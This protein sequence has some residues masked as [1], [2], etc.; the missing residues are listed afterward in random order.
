MALKNIRKINSQ[1]F[2][3]E[4]SNYCQVLKNDH[5][6]KVICRGCS[7]KLKVFHDFYN[8][9]NEARKGFL[10]VIMKNIDL[11]CKEVNFDSVDC[12]DDIP[13]VKL[14][15]VADIFVTEIET[16][17]LEG[18]ISD[19]DRMKNSSVNH[20]DG[21]DFRN[22]EF[23]TGA[24]ESEF[25]TATDDVDAATA[26]NVSPETAGKRENNTAVKPKKFRRSSGNFD[27]L[28]SSYV[29]MFCDIC[30]QPFETL[31]EATS[32]YRRNHN[33]KYM[34]VK[35]CQRRIFIPG[36]IRDHIQYHLN[37]VK[38]K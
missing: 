24:D 15:P 28:I 32:H 31:T 34:Y 9:V 35:C 4:S 6:P 29:N 5:L 12:D 10:L 14:E 21:V 18:N 30:E 37:P 8:A 13:L 38:F 11:N 26:L 17:S 23:D 33:R 36:E 2:E 3:F 19:A 7:T 16:S 22:D 1:R 27:Y 20:F 25:D